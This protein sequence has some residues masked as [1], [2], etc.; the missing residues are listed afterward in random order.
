MH[1]LA[2]CGAIADIVTRRA[3]GREVTAVHVRIG[4][5]RQVVPDTLTYCWSMVAADTTLDG[6]VLEV[7]QIPVRL[8]CASCGAEEDLGDSLVL[9][10]QLCAS[11]D[12]T[13]VSGEELLVTALDL[14]PA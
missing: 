12:V 11:L 3:E 9:V 14:A 2:L 5:L 6:S 4:Q 7:E 10:C 1:E 13:V 8:S